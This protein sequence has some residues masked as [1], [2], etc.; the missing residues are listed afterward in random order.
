MKS[1]Y[2]YQQGIHLWESFKVSLDPRFA[3]ISIGQDTMNDIH[4]L[5]LTLVE[6]LEGKY[7]NTQKWHT[8]S[9]GYDFSKSQE[10]IFLRDFKKDHQQVDYFLGKHVDSGVYSYAESLPNLS[11]NLDLNLYS[12]AHSICFLFAKEDTL[13]CQQ[14]WEAF[15]HMDKDGITAEGLKQSLLELKGGIIMR[16]LNRETHVAIQFIGF[17]NQID[18]LL[19]VINGMLIERITE[20]MVANWI[21]DKLEAYSST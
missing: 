19:T 15:K 10:Y 11:K 14:V 2:I 8:T 6:D 18:Q 17:V 9:Y 5:W 1:I 16:L 4:K 12:S 21:N 13:C 3:T 20:D 7:P